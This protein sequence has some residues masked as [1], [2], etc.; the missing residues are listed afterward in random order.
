LLKEVS[1]NLLNH[2]YIF[3]IYR[4]PFITS[5]DAET[6]IPPVTG[7]QEITS[8]DSSVAIT[9]P[10]GAIT[11]LS[12]V[13]PQ[14]GWTPPDGTYINDLLQWDPAQQDWFSSDGKLQLGNAA[15][16]NGS[17]L[18]VAIGRVSN[19]SGYMT[20]AIGDQSVASALQSTAIGAQSKATGSQHNVSIGYQAGNTTQT[21]GNRGNTICIGSFCGKGTC[22]ANNIAIGTS[23]MT[24]NDVWGTGNLVMGPF[25][26]HDL[27]DD[28]IIL[29]PDIFNQDGS[30]PQNLGSQNIIIR[31]GKNTGGDAALMREVRLMDS[32]IYLKSR[33]TKL[34]I[35]PQAVGD[36]VLG[37]SDGKVFEPIPAT[38]PAGSDII[39][40]NP[41]CTL[42]YNF[43]NN[44]HSFSFSNSLPL[45][46]TPIPA[47]LTRGEYSPSNTAGGWTSDGSTLTRW[48]GADSIDVASTCTISMGRTINQE[49]MAE[50]YVVKNGSEV[51]GVG[52]TSDL[53]RVS[54]GQGSS[55]M[56][57]KYNTTL[58]TNDYITFFLRRVGSGGATTTNIDVYNVEIDIVSYN[59]TKLP[60]QIV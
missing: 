26:S 60:L 32:D 54:F 33:L 23:L 30:L 47:D 8:N 27:G 13:P 18:N 31:A 6:V 1:F 21:T 49:V 53:N 56:I 51:V 4:M 41:R 34:N 35:T 5:I 16:V 2:N 24:P 48:T 17:I 11:D 45:Q 19:A 29:H 59:K 50:L 22:L 44:V 9:N 57:L 10:F 58:D 14:P 28:N 42:Y 38:A 20:C 12:V 25:Y 39:Y 43:K 7:I 55:T 37:S 40:N 46:V 36:W 3:V 15:T 52:A